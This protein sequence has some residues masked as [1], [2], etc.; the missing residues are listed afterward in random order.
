VKQLTVF[1]GPNGS[2][3]TTITDALRESSPFELGVYL[4]P[5]KIEALLDFPGFIPLNLF[6][7]VPTHLGWDEFLNQSSLADK[8]SREAGIPLNQLAGG[9]SFYRQETEVHMEVSSS[10]PQAY[11]AAL[12]TDFIRQMLIVKGLSFSLKR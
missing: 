3:K 2:G 5:D 12:I 1:A 9:F 11:L 8:I 7:I 4:N 10:V 6:D